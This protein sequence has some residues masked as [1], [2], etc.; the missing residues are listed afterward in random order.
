MAMG[1]WVENPHRE[2]ALSDVLPCVDQRTT[3]KTLFQSKQVVT[4]IANIVNMAIYN[5]AN[6]NVTEGHPG[7]YNQSGPPMPPLCY[8]FD[9]QF[10]ERQCTNQEVS[11]ANASMVLFSSLNFIYQALLDGDFW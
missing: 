3:N 7:F 10:R 2:S 6:L 11:S 8:P 5:T 4:N 9:G 1:E